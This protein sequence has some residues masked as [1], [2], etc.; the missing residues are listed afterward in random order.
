MEDW[1]INVNKFLAFSDQEM[2][3]NAGDISHEMAVAKAH[4]EYDKFRVKQDRLYVSDFDKEFE[5][6]IKGENR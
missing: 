5:K 6:C 2:L 4:E 1:L 3:E